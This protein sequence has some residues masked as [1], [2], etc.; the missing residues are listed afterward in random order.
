[1]SGASLS[2]AVNFDDE[3]D[4]ASKPSEV[5]TLTGDEVGNSLTDDDEW[6]AAP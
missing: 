3:D 2:F 5:G 6:G 1:M 4:G